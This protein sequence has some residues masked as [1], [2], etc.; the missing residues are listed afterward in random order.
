MKLIDDPLVMISRNFISG[1]L[2]E[3]EDLTPAGGGSITNFIYQFIKDYF[4]EIIFLG[5]D[6]CYKDLNM[7]VA[8]TYLNHYFLKR[9]TRAESLQS[10]YLKF[11]LSRAKRKIKFKDKEYATTMSM[12]NYFQGIVKAIKG[13]NVCFSGNS[14][15]DF[16]NIK[17]IDINEIKKTEKKKD[18][19]LIKKIPVSDPISRLKDL[20]K[21]N[22]FMN[23]L[24]E[25]V[26]LSKYIDKWQDFNDKEKKSCHNKYYEYLKKKIERI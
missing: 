20:I 11:Y 1:F 23:S 13:K 24:T 17:K 6:L 22:D 14:L 19:F 7:Y 12:I 3:K 8:H 21:N 4:D 2:F 9:N 26:I 10:I 16:D 5:L 25:A 15:I 18:I